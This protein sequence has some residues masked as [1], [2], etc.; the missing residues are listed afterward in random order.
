MKEQSKVPEKELKKIETSN[1]PVAEFKTL[2]IRRFNK[3][4]E[5]V[6]ELNGNL[7]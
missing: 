1:L 4:R 5:R 6:D 3:V 7:N 2:L